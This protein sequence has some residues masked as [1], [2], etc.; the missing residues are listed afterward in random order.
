MENTRKALEEIRKGSNGYCTSEVAS[1][2]YELSALVEKAVH[3]AEMFISKYKLDETQF[4]PVSGHEAAKI[5]NDM[6]Y[7]TWI[8]TDYLFD[9]KNL[10][11]RLTNVS[12]YNAPIEGGTV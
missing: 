2:L 1:D 6:Y 11:E 8:L 3:I 7:D 9:A 10:A 12:V 4:T 5:K